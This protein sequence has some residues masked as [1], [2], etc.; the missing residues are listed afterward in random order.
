MENLSYCVEDL[1]NISP[2]NRKMRY[3]DIIRMVK[4]LDQ[5]DQEQTK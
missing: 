5:D 4:Y 1:K 2:C 3:E